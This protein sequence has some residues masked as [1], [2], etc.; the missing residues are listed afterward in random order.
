MSDNE[1]GTYLRIRREALTPSAVGLPVGSRRRTPGLRRAEVATLAG[2]SVEYLTR[3]EQG[4][5]RHP[6][7]QILGALADALRLT[8]DERLRLR[9]LAKA[10]DGALVCHEVQPPAVTVRPTVR[11]L[12]DRLE[13][14]PACVVNRL[15]DVL[16]YTTAYERLAGPLGLL[17]TDPPNLVRFAFTDAR[18]RSA[19]PDWERV[20]D[21]RVATLKADFGPPDP[22]VRELVDELTVTAGAAFA[23]RYRLITGGEARSGVERLRHPS[24][25]ELRLAYESLVLPDADQQQLVTYLP[26]DDAAAAALDLLAGRR[27]GALRVA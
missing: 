10:A 9:I 27:P 19:Y 5:D 23:D 15:G 6:S 3:I 7:T 13:P 26:A 17:D 2:L 22:H 11:A 24:A 16:A 1:L 12:L 21:A 4:R 20:A 18:A 14:T 8:T 25:G